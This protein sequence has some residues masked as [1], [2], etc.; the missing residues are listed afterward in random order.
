MYIR[1]REVDGKPVGE[2]FS[3]G[4]RNGYI[5]AGQF[6]GDIHDEL[7]ELLIERGFCEEISAEE[8][9]QLEADAEAAAAE[10]AA[11]A[12]EARATAAAAEEVALKGAIVHPEE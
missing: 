4:A 9:L 1:I 10:A 5:E 2:R 12:E 11:A 6:R 8:V 7:C 3:L